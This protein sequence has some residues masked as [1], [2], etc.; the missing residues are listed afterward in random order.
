M[1]VPFA[2]QPLI[3]VA[4]R[5]FSGMPHPYLMAPVARIA[6]Q[7]VCARREAMLKV[8]YESEDQVVKWSIIDLSPSARVQTDKHPLEDARQNVE[9]PAVIHPQAQQGVAKP[10]EVQKAADRPNELKAVMPYQSRFHTASHCNE[11]PFPPDPHSDW[12]ICEESL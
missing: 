8:R 9:A 7:V 6:S 5:F 3:R 1:K 11:I 10:P 4:E 2:A 12:D